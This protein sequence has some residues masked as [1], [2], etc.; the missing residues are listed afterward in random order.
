VDIRTL[1]LEGP[2]LELERRADGSLRAPGL[3]ALLAGE[4]GEAGK[5]GGLPPGLP[6]ELVIRDG[7]LDLRDGRVEGGPVHLSLRDLDVDLELEH[8]RARAVVELSATNPQ[9][10]QLSVKGSLDIAEPF[11]RSRFEA[12]VRGRSLSS[13]TA[14]LYLLFGL[15]VRNPGGVFD[16]AGTVAGDLTGEVAGSAKLH[17]P[18][19]S[20][21]GWDLIEL[22]APVDLAADFRVESRRF[23]MQ[24]AVLT[25]EALAFAGLSG[26]ATRADFDW[27]DDTLT[28]H[29]LAVAAYS[30]RWEAAGS[31]TFDG[32]PRYQGELRAADV[33]VRALATDVSGRPVEENFATLGGHARL[34]GAVGAGDWWRETSGSGAVRLAG[35]ELS[36]SRVLGSLLHGLIVL[37]PELL[38]NFSSAKGRATRLESLTA[39]FDV[40]QGVAKT[41]DLVL[42]TSDYRMSGAGSVELDGTLDIQGR[43][44]LS[45]HGVEKLVVLLASPLRGFQGDR[46]PEIPVRITGP[47][48]EPKVTSELRKV[49]FAPVRSLMGGARNALGRL[50]PHRR[51]GSEP[52]SEATPE[53]DATTGAPTGGEAWD[54]STAR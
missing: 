5:G 4:T 44:A 29:D 47:I 54:D 45:A 1:R 20:V 14:L 32:A 9:G 28:L 15:P 23:A 16:V 53:P 42:E 46:L 19:G 40:S 10:A 48:G 12:R 7:S 21:R 26:E 6:R 11:E 33:N 38:K 13:D 51:S 36:S 17:V 22:T 3:E 18:R 39:S 25:G 2:V 27:S 49:P 34:E 8:R 30:G 35:G 37:S 41:D 50:V 31:V 24:G 52:A 43:V